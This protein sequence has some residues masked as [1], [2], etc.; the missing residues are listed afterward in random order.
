VFRKVAINHATWVSALQTYDVIAGYIEALK[1]EAE[2]PHP[3]LRLM[4]CIGTACS[5]CSCLMSR[6]PAIASTLL[7]CCLPLDA[8]RWT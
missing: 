5:D 6:R 8:G 2:M 1:S 4:L 7:Q 3:E